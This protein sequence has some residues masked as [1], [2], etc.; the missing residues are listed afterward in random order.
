MIEDLR[1]HPLLIGPVH[2]ARYLRQHRRWPNMLRPAGFNEK[3]IHR[4]LFDR[5]P[6]L[7]RLTGKLEVRDWVLERTGDPS[8]LIDLVGTAED[9]AGLA[10]LDLP[11]DFVVKANHL[12][13]FKLFHRGAGAPDIAGMGEQVARWVRQVPKT[14][15]PYLSLRRTALVERLLLVGDRTAHDVKFMCYDGR[16]RFIYIVTNRHGPGGSKIDIF[17]ADWTPVEGRWAYDNAPQ[18]PP[19]P[20]LLDR[21]IATAEKLSAGLDF[22]RVDMYDCDDHYK[23]GEI[24]TVPDRGMAWFDPP[25][26]DT[27]FGAPWRL[28]GK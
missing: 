6:V 20:R 16:V 21:M 12:S 27:L 10:R 13:G 24:T 18:R 11:Q 3:V 23:T 4:L 1:F 25:E 22:V 17:D 9:A 14:E 5:R 15:W 28:P 19:P 8:L 2:V 26:I 7:P